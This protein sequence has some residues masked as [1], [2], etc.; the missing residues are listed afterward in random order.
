MSGLFEWFIIGFQWLYNTVPFIQFLGNRINIVGATWLI[1][2]AFITGNFLR[3]AKPF[4]EYRKVTNLFLTNAIGAILVYSFYKL[5]DSFFMASQIFSGHDYM[6]SANLPSWS[7][8]YYW[9]NFAST[10]LVMAII[11]YITIRAFK[12]ESYLQFNRRSIAFVML[13]VGLWIYFLTYFPYDYA[14]L[15]GQQR[16]TVFWATY[17]EIYLGYA[18]LYLSLWKHV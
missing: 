9:I 15:S 12:L 5:I 13:V 1:F 2:L 8:T 17:P 3:K 16:I 14:V 6:V 4:N 7:W 10:F 18:L 11:A